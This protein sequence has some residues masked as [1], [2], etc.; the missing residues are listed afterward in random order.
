[1]KNAAEIQN[2]RKKQF[3]IF[4]T[5]LMI[6]TI[7]ALTFVDLYEDDF[8]EFIADLVVLAVL[9]GGYIAIRFMQRDLAVFRVIIFLIILNFYYSVNIGAGEETVLFWAFFMPPLFFYFFG[10]WEGMIWGGAFFLSLGGLMFFP[11]LFKGHVYSSVTVSRFMIA[12]PIVTV[13][14][15]G[16]ESS[17]D[18]FSRMLDSRNRQLVQ[19]KKQLETAL[20]EIKTLSGLIPI[21]AGC[22]SIRNDEGYWERVETYIEARSAVDFTHG[23]CPDCLKR[24]YPDLKIKEKSEQKS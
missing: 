5:W 7:G 15:F 24:L 2:E 10:K 9:F 23:L 4:C 11:F 22:K 6:F 21:C 17:R 13:V 14:C 8:N 18:L 12:L 20:K 3:F 1:M 16:L 19:E